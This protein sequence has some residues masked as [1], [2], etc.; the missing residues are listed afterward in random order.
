[1][2]YYTALINEWPNLTPGT[3]AAKLA[4][5]NAMTVNGSVPTVLNVSGNQLANCINYSEFKALTSTQQANILAL[6]RIQGNLL[7]GSSNT[8]LLTDGM[9]LDYFSPS[10]AT[11][12]NLTALAQA[13]VT[14]WWQANG[15]SSPIS[16]NDLSA[17]GG[18][19]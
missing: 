16:L 19:T 10:G 2:A 9:F 8:S 1:M 13:T 6:C 7:G 5:I 18:L 14:P 3:T 12:T 4:Q 15:Y 11:I 17:A